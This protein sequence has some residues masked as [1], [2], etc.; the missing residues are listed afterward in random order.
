[1]AGTDTR[2]IAAGDLA[3]AVVLLTRIPLP[4][5]APDRGAR[6]AWAWP[7]TGLLVG[8][9]SA[10]AGWLVSTAGGPP[11]LAAGAA[12]IAAVAVTGALH[13]DGLADVADGFWGGFD[14]ARRLDIMRDSHV[15]SYGVIALVAS[16]GLRAAAIAALI[17]SQDWGAIVVAAVLSRM[18]MAAVMQALPPV[19]Q[20]GL[21][22]R[23][24]RPG[25][26]RSALGAA[27][28]V[29]LAL[30]ICGGGAIWAAS[31]V[32][33]AALATGALAHAKIGGQTGDVLGATQQV[34]E[35][36]ALSVFV[37]LL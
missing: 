17:G 31:A 13:E 6:S 16:L 28:A 37:A 2:P 34:S 12:V 33:L 19:R 24:G 18:P 3:A 35:I 5:A 7:L 25:W 29:G 1:M 26:G 8:G 30:G 9:L 15:G 11:A 27:L 21:S 4:F 36:V 23:V 10:L 22:R 32:G 20:D 14:P